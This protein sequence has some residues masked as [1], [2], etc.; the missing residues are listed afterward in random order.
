[1][2]ILKKYLKCYSIITFF[3]LSVISLKAQKKGYEPPYYGMSPKSYNDFIMEKLVPVIQKLDC[4]N[5]DSLLLPSLKVVLTINKYGVI[6]SVAFPNLNISAD[7]KSAI[8]KAFFKMK[9]WVP[10]QINGQKLRSQHTY[11]IACLKWEE[12]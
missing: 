5:E 9:G 12:L 4:R 2:D 11:Y 10:G 8:S 3:L 7:C 6:D 1:M